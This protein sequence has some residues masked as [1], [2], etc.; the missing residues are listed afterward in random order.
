MEKIWTGLLYLLFG[1]IILAFVGVVTMWLLSTI[2]KLTGPITLNT[3][4][5]LLL[6]KIPVR[7]LMLLIK[8]K[9]NETE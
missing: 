5:F 3:L 1:I 4:A 9:K 6:M 2:I 7:I 8:E